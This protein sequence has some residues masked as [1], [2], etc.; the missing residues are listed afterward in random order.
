MTPPLEVPLPSA[1]SVEAPERV[2]HLAEGALDRSYRLAGLILGDQSEAEDATQDALL[3]AWRSAAS[4]RDPAGFSAWFD[5]ILVNV[6][7]DRLRKR[8]K[9]RFLALDE[10]GSEPIERDPF[11]SIFDRD[12]V[13]RALATLDDDLRIVLLL[14]YWADLT[15]DAVAERVG[16][17]VGTVKSRLH[18]GL[19]ELRRRIEAPDAAE[20]GT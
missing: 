5:R 11:R 4:L 17:P 13:L 2:R 15:L 3:R 1:S 14:H 7:R 19:D 10:I 18:R 12:Q 9:V 8:G 6:C 20:V 16:W